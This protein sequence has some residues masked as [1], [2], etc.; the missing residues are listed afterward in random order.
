MKTLRL[1]SAVA[2]TVLILA[3]SCQKTGSGPLPPEDDRTIVG[4]FGTLRVL[5]TTLVDRNDQPVALHGMSLFWSQWGGKYYNESCV[6]WLRDDWRCTV[7][8]AACG[9][10]M[11][12]YLDNPAAEMAKVTAVVEAA[13]KLG[14]YVIID[15]HD[16]NAQN[17]LEEAKQFFR[18]IAQTYGDK[19]NIIYEVFNEPLQVSWGSVI[20]PYTEAV[21]EVIREYDPDNLILVGSPTWSQDVDVAAANP[22]DDA[23]VAYTLHFY[24]GTHR[25]ALRTKAIT[26]IGRGA[27]LFVSE[28]GISEATGDGIIDYGETGRWFGFVDSLGLSTCNW[29]V[30]DKVET[31][32]ALKPGASAAG[33]WSAAD[34]TESGAYIRSRIRALNEDLFTSL[35]IGK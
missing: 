33:G 32:A 3:L 27:P 12:G 9:V 8:R 5:G 28:F 18:F 10:E 6:Q 11:G 19:P 13:I 1:F 26:A 23:N 24:T 4:H 14:I 29:S 7:V 21:I 16:H 30:M 25:Q 15:W 17:H 2:V 22:I 20:K 34:L 31:S 35:N